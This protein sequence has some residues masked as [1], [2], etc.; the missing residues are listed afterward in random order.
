MRVFY[1]GR[2]GI[3][4]VGRISW[5]EENRKTRRKT[6]W[7]GREPTTNST[8]IGHRAGIEPETQ[9]QEASALT[10][11]P[12]LLADET[13]KLIIKTDARLALRHA[14]CMYTI[15]RAVRFFASFGSLHSNHFL[16]NL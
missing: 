11:V 9:W 10:T 4:N 12:P 7:A 14:N 3:W 15:L 13:V 2:I 1:P 5:R 8:H 16:C 6:L